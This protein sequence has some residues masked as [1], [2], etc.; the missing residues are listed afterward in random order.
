[1]KASASLYLLVLALGLLSLNAAGARGKTEPAAE[2]SC[3]ERPAFWTRVKERGADDYCRLVDRARTRLYT[4]PDEAKDLS[5]RASKLRPPGV[6][7]ELVHAHAELLLGDSSAAHRDFTR[8]APDLSSP[9]VSPFLTPTDVAAGARAALLEGAFV[10]ALAR[11]RWVLLRLDEFK[12]PQEE[13]RLLIEAATAAEYAQED[14]GREARAYL[15]LAEAKN[16]PLL[17]PIIQAARALSLLRDGDVER[18]AREA[19]HFESTWA[20]AWIFEG[21]STN[22]APR[23]PL[24]VLPRGEKFALLA[25]V[26][27]SVEREVAAENWEQFFEEAGPTIPEHLKRSPVE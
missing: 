27:E 2:L 1:M 4:A 6:S 15:S 24:P 8:V 12:S 13:A 17:R 18:S 22:G 11:Y 20:L 16:A 10:Y 19:A 23:E 25:A 3:Y 7:A 21:Q 26:A 5:E 14:G 9:K